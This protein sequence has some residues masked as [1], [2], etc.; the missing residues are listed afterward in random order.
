MI[1]DLRSLPDGTH[2][3]C[4]LCVVGAGAAGISIARQFLG[5]QVSVLLVES[6]GFGFE[7]STQA[8]YEFEN[9]GLPRTRDTR[10]RIFGGTTSAWDGRCAMLSA[11]DFPSR[12]WLPHSGWPI[13]EADLRPY[14]VA[15]HDACGLAHDDLPARFANGVGAAAPTLHP[16]KLRSHLWQFGPGGPKRFGEMHRAELAASRNVDVLLHANVT[17]L[18]ANSAASAVE[19]IH[20]RTL[21][22]KSAS[23]RARYTVL[24]AG[25]I[26]NARLLLLS[27]NVVPAGLGNGRDLVG[28]F[29]MDHPRQVAGTILAR[30]PFRFADAFLAHRLPDG[31]RLLPGV[32]LAPALQAQEGLLTCGAL[33]FA[34][35]AGESGT[36]ALRRL[37]GRSGPAPQ[38]VGLLQDIGRVMA[39]LD[40]ILV[41]TRRR[42]LSPAKES[43][44]TPQVI[45]MLCDVEQSP[46][47]ASRVTLGQGRDSLGLRKARVEW[48]VT[49]AERRTVR[50][51]AFA[52]GEEFGR[53][54]LGRV[55]VDDALIEA[56]GPPEFVEAHHHMGTTRMASSP[57][58][59]VVNPNGKVFGIDNLYVAGS[60]VF[61]TSGHV[62]PTLTLVSLSLRLADHL[63]SRV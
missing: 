13:T 16:D 39:D 33:F 3:E 34:Q 59:G 11:S 51:L 60:S 20:L 37:L 24:C 50:A 29:L 10:F 5:G 1:D 46:N 58:D 4:D 27:N 9:A 30:D 43:V 55:R 44:T 52:A 18:D 41:N 25:G 40:E 54:N 2:L 45:T 31:T 42:V 28:R 57:V 62:N 12:P 17:R 53:L 26:E 14:R 48:R 21:E 6:G 47:P 36:D 35:T 61:S 8:L 38:S 7:E 22:G 63:R 23:V 49:D 15:A 19:T 56:D 32:E